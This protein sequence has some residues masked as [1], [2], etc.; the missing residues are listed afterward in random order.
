[1]KIKS[2]SGEVVG[3]TTLNI[4]VTYDDGKGDG[5]ITYYAPV[6]TQP[7]SIYYSGSME[8]D[9]S[10][11]QSL[12]PEFDFELNEYAINAGEFDY[13]EFWLYEVDYSDLSLGHWVIMSG[14]LGEVRT[15]D[16]ITVWGEMRSITD[17]YKKAICPLYSLTCR[18]KFGDAM[19]GYDVST[20][21]NSGV[22]EIVGTEPNRTF[23]DTTNRTEATGFY[24]PGVIEFLTGANAGRTVE[25]ESS[26]VDF[27]ALNFPTPYDIQVGD[28]YRI[29]RDCNKRARDTEKGCAH[30]WGAEW[31]L[32]FRGEPDIPVGEAGQATTPGASVGPGSG[33]ATAGIIGAVVDAGEDE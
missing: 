15:V 22:V 10:E 7:A 14:T 20:L 33:G 27:I 26:D 31:P 6:G 8:V 21:W 29:R 28:T 30:W 11:F 17:Q 3:M 12:V 23:Y 5:P 1:M 32:H 16:G 4:N 24:E 9:N 19:C 13:A 25:I 2:K 18:A